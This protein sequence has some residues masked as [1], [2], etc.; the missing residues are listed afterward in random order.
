MNWPLLFLFFAIYS[1]AS[2]AEWGYLTNTLPTSWGAVESNCNGLRQS[3]I[4]IPSRSAVYDY[5]LKDIIIRRLDTSA[6][7]SWGLERSSYGGK[8]GK[9]STE[10]KLKLN[11]TT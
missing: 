5:G 7:E 6:T 4:D 9:K 8:Y 2:A 11:K 1:L 3:P 10:L